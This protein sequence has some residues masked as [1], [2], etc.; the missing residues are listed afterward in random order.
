MTRLIKRYPNRKLYDTV[1]RRYIALRDIAT[2]VREGI[3]LRVVEHES[4]ED[5][6]ARTLSQ[7]ILNQQRSGGGVSHKVLE[8]LVRAGDW[9]VETM[10]SSLSITRDVARWLDEELQAQLNTSA[11]PADGSGNRM[12][13][14]LQGMLQLAGIEQIWQIEQRLPHVWERLNLAS[15]NDLRELEARL[16]E[17]AQR[18]AELGANHG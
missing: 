1:A 14:A 12:R 4:Q 9:G 10:R 2:M 11:V 6:T 16:D 3:A 5:I 18:I 17:L 15:H 7:I 8:N 13:F